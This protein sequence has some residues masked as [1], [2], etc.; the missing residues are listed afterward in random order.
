MDKFHDLLSVQVLSVGMERIKSTLLPMLTDIL[1]K[2]GQ[3]TRGVY[4]RNDV[5]LRNKEGLPQ[6]KAGSPCQARRSPLPP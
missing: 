1:R 4:E 3:V 6:Y 2:D 5:A